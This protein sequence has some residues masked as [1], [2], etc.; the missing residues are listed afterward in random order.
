MDDVAPFD[1]LSLL[2]SGIICVLFSI[3][4]VLILYIFSPS[5]QRFNRNQ[6]NVILRR[7]LAVVFLCFVIY[8][9]LKN[10][11]NANVNI[12]HWLGFRTNICS[13]WKL[14][15]CPILLTCL[16][17]TGPIVQWIIFREWQDLSFKWTLNEKAVFLRN[18]LVAPF[19]EGKTNE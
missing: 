17:Y 13:I 9:V 15:F 7:F 2:S 11:S 16:L 12:H 5:N 3:G 10:L 6:S 19:S 8:I 18:Y 1:Y 14:I 4:Y